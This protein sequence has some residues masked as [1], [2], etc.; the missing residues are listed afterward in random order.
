MLQ[1]RFDPVISR[2]RARHHHCKRTVNRAL[3][4]AADGCIDQ[5]QV[6]RFESLRDQFGGAGTRG[7]QVDQDGGAVSGNDSIGPQRDGL[8]DVR[9]RQAG[10]HDVGARRDFGR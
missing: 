10:Q 3:D 1:D 7:G 8:D 2:L 6:S 5:R 4:A 9:R